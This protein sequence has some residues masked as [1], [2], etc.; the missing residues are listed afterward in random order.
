MKPDFLNVIPNFQ[1]GSFD[2]KININPISPKTG[3]IEPPSFSFIE[4]GTAFR[5]SDSSAIANEGGKDSKA[6][7]K[8]RINIQLGVKDVIFYFTGL[9]HS[10]ERAEKMRILKVGQDLI[11]EAL[12]VRS[13]IR[14][15]N[16]ID[17]LHSFLREKENDLYYKNTYRP[18]V[19]LPGVGSKP[20]I[21][22]N[23]SS[24]RE[25]TEDG[26]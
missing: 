16:E 10:E 21:I 9:F 18:K 24:R 25:I 12:D 22:F 20:D 17:R 14:K 13:I 11:M 4:M 23:V 7:S 1:I 2:P 3:E 19:E 15:I 8:Q 5:G 26:N 6:S